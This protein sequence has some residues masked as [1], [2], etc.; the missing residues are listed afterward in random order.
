MAPHHTPLVSSLADFVRVGNSQRT[1]EEERLP[2]QV[3]KAW[4]QGLDLKLCENS[5]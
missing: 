3:R 1:A 2:P 4:M 5:I